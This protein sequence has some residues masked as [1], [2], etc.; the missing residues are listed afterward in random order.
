MSIKQKLNLIL[1]KANLPADLINPWQDAL[2]YLKIKDL[3]LL[4]ETLEELSFEE[5][6]ELSENLKDKIAALEGEDTGLWNKI[7]K[8]E[9]DSLK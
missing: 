3:V 7:I 4:I 1:E 6:K 9:Q 2:K 5:I 8:Q